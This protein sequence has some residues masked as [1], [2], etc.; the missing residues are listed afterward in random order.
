MASV[1][2]V[3]HTQADEVE[4]KAVEVDNKPKQVRI[5]VETIEITALEYADLMTTPTKSSNHTALRNALLEKVAKGEAKLISNQSLVAMSGQRSTVES[6]REY[7]YE[8]EYEPG[9]TISLKDGDSAKTIENFPVMPPTPTAFET[10]NLGYTLQVEP[11]IGED[12]KVVSVTFKRESVEHVDENLKAEWKTKYADVKLQMPIFY[13]LRA[14]TSVVLFDGEFLLVNSYSPEKN[15]KTDHMR[16][17][18]QFVRAEI[19]D[20]KVA[21]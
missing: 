20:K 19:L 13:T 17:L 4:V 2:L 16:K 7:I 6:I 8:T 1:F 3:H 18:L 11:T 10:R 21:K 9:E 15:G 12:V 5:Y 14:D